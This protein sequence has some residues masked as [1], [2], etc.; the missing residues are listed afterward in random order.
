MIRWF[1]VDRIPVKRR[2]RHTKAGHAYTDERTKADM[3][4]VADAYNGGRYFGPVAV[5]IIA[6]KPLPKSA[7]KSK[8]SEAFVAKPDADNIA[9]AVL[10]GLKGKAFEDDKQVTKLYCEKRE[11]E[12]TGYP[13]TRFTVL[14]ADALSVEL[15]EK[16]IFGE[17]EDET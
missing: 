1:E 7:P 8:E 6:Y 5:L 4:A 9:K 10:D 13:F 16:S 12:R 11:R 2:A 17:I 3:K 14:S 15:L